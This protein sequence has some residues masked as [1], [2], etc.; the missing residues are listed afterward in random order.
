V[1]P[2]WHGKEAVAGVD[3]SFNYPMSH[4]LLANRAVHSGQGNPGN[5]WSSECGGEL[6][7]SHT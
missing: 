7:I 1:L 5:R 3:E 6:G 4:D 2:L